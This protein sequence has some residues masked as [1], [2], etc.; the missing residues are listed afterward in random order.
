MFWKG[1]PGKLL[2]LHSPLMGSTLSHALLTRQSESGMPILAKLCLVHFKGTLIGSILLHSPLMGSTLSQAL[3]TRQLESGMLIL[4]ML[5]LTHL[6]D[7][8]GLFFWMKSFSTRSI[9]LQMLSLLQSEFGIQYHVK[10]C[11]HH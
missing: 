6:R 10:L 7:I 5:Y 2:L 11:L 9:S 1:T 4:A 3:L 8:T